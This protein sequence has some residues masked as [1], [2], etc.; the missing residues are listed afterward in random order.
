MTCKACKHEFCWLCLE[1][2]TPDHFN[3]RQLTSCAGRMFTTSEQE[4]FCALFCRVFI[5]Y[6]FV[7]SFP[8][9]LF[10]F[11][12]FIIPIFKY[13]QKYNDIRTRT[14]QLNQMHI[15]D[16]R[17]QERDRKATMDHLGRC[18]LFG[19]SLVSVVVFPFTLIIFS[20]PLAIILFIWSIVIFVILWN[21]I[22]KLFCCCKKKPINNP[23]PI[24]S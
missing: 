14:R 17:F 22:S 10:I 9:L 24:M 13:W 4:S 23:E 1:D 19:W 12:L 20:I 21:L 8:V 2:F 3:P 5:V 18:K 7:I 15:H 11:L 6:F 16:N